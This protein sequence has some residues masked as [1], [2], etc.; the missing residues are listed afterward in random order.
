MLTDLIIRAKVHSEFGL[1]VQISD[2]IY[3][4]SL[5]KQITATHTF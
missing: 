2:L 3:D 4:L 1:S 5:W